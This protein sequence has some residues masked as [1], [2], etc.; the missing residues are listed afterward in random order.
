M[1]TLRKHIAF[2]L[3]GIFFF[4]ITFQTFHGVWDHSDDNITENQNCHHRVNDDGSNAEGECIYKTENTCPICDYQ[5]S[6]N[7]I[8]KVPFF[9][10]EIPE[11]TSLYY[12]IKRNHHYKQVHSAKS[13]RGPPVYSS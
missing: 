9:S 5:F 1:I 13:P 6:I 2:L 12:E 8:P 10:S 7:D 4:P 11:F 3:F